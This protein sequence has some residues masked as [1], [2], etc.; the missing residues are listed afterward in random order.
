MPK[1]GIICACDIELEPFL[2][3]IQNCRHSEKSMLKLYEG[4]IHGVQIVALYSGVCKTNAAVATQMLIDHYPVD[5]VI[6][7]GA[8]GGMDET[9]RVFDTVI[10]TEVA[11]HDMGE[12]ILTEYH[13]WMPSVYFPSD[14]TLLRLTK[15][16][17]TRCRSE[18]EIYYGRMVT[19]EKFIT[20]EGR[21]DINAAF[22]PLSVDMETASMAQVCYVNK[23]PFIAIRCITDTATHSGSEN[24][25]KNC[26]IAAQISKD[27]VLELLIELAKRDA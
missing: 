14:E 8:A 21:A 16:A 25:E 3:H 9:L 23:I 2:P 15:E 22:A 1:V 27:I 18:H 5:Y 4:T 17:A 24:F 6:N 26:K 20:D 11:H 7:A 10:A 19:G 13:P 12:D